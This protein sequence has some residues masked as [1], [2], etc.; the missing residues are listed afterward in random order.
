M[1][2]SPFLYDVENTFLVPLPAGGHPFSDI[3]VF[4]HEAE[5]CPDD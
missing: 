1:L 5:I 3:L 4:S 2:G